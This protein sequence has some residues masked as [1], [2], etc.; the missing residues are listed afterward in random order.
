MTMLL[1][2]LKTEGRVGKAFQKRRKKLKSK[3]EE[4]KLSQNWEEIKKKNKTKLKIDSK[5][6]LNKKLIE[7]KILQELSMLFG[8]GKILFEHAY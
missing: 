3:K 1:L 5:L 4:E 6:K 2:E 7:T 8:V